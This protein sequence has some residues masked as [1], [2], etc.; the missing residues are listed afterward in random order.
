MA[1]LQIKW[2]RS[3]IGLPRNQRRVIVALGLR[4]LQQTVVHADTPIIRGMVHKVRHMVT[5]EEIPE[6]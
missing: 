5:V 6:E 2:T 3:G 1:K 4:R